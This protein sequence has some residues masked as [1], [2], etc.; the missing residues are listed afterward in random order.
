MET[1]NGKKKTNAPP[2]RFPG[3]RGEWEEKR[4]GEVCTSLSGGTPNSSVRD[5][6]GGEI[7]F[8][9]SGELHFDNTEL[10]ITQLGYDNSAAKMVCAGDLLLAMYG[11]TSGDIAISKIDGAIN[12]A[13]LCLQTKQNK[14]FI[15]AVWNKH[16]SQILRKYLQ[17]GQGNLSADIV[18][19]ISFHFPTL[20]EQRKIADFL[21]LLDERIAAQRALIGE[22][23]RLIGGIREWLFAHQQEMKKCLLGDI[24]VEYSERNRGKNRKAVAV[25]KSGIRKREELFSRELSKDYSA[26]KVIRKNTLTIGMGSNQIDFGILLDDKEFCVSPAYT[27]YQ[28]VGVD[29]AYLQELLTWLNPI[30]SFKYMITSVRQGKTVNKDELM[31]HPINLCADEEQHRIQHILSTVG[32]KIELE[33]DALDLYQRQKQFFLQQLFI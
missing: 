26:N 15:E 32:K 28:I 22:M 13:I 9:R 14:K 33:R 19:S 16:V 25:G 29:S 8:I 6:Y 2:L 20:P 4:L 10:F 12:Q 31:R 7:P 1:D 17:G 18:K 24:L 11:A 23:G 5:Y 30:L 27:T 3:F 21:R